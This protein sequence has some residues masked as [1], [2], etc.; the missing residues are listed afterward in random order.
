MIEADE[1]T[2]QG[3]EGLIEVRAPLV[4]DRQPSVPIEPRQ[5]PFDHPA[6]AAQALAGV[7]PPPGDADLDPAPVQQASATRD[8]VGL[9]GMELG[10]PFPPL[11]RRLG[12]QGHGIKQLLEDGAVVAVRLGQETGQG[13]AATV[14]DQVPLRAWFA[15]IGGIRADRIAPLFAG[16]VALSR[17]AR[18]Q[19]IRPASPSRSSN[20][21]CNRSQTPATCQSRKR[22]QQVTPEPQPI[23]C[24]SI[25]H[26]M[27]DRR[28]KRMPVKAARSGARG[29]PPLGLGGAGGSSGSTIT[30]NS[31]GR[32]GLLIG[33]FYHGIIRF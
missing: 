13:N 17:L 10:G 30:H 27:P 16:T 31:S 7:G 12:N 25:S 1:G 6:V 28:T 5:G 19:S 24:G 18:L 3:Q 11:A 29:R 26:G 15:A 2:A 33:T 20:V 8:V 4:P 22:R 32:R 21:R 9:V 14:A 23:S